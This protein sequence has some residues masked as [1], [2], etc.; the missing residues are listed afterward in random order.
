MGSERGE[1]PN[2]KAAG[3][4]Q[5]GRLDSVCVPCPLAESQAPPASGVQTL[6]MLAGLPQPSSQRCIYLFACL[7]LCRIVASEGWDCLL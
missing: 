2:E 4:G 3:R 5:W 1:V 7:S 6:P